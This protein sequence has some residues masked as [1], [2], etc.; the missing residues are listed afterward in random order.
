LKV[1]LGENEYFFNP[2]GCVQLRA[3]SEVDATTARFLRVHTHNDI[4]TTVLFSLGEKSIFQ[5]IILATDKA[6]TAV[7][8]E[9][10]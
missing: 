7:L 1:A 3:S 10:N 6:K 5:I 9:D 4:I 2:D 8:T